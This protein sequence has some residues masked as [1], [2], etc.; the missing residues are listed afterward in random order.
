MRHKSITLLLVLVMMLAGFVS[1]IYIPK[2]EFPQ[3]DL[4][5]GLVVGVYPGASELEVE[6]Q[7]T[8][9]LEDF[10]WTFKEIDRGKTLTMSM[11]DGCAA[12]VWLNGTE[13]SKTEFWNKLK[14][15]LTL[16][17]MTLPAG[18]L[19]VVANDDFGDSSALLVTMESDDKT[20]RQLSDYMDQLKDRL[21]RVESVGRMTVTGMQKDQVSIILDNDRLARY[22]LSDR[23]LAM[24]LFSKGITTTAGRI[25]DE[26]SEQPI[27]VDRSEASVRDIEEMIVLSTPAGNVVRLK[28]VAEVRREYPSPDSYITNNG[29]KCLLLSVEMKK[30]KDI[31]AMGEAVKEQIAEFQEKQATSC[32]ALKTGA[33]IRINGGDGISY[34]QRD[35]YK[36]S[37]ISD[38]HIYFDQVTVVRGDYGNEIKV[39]QGDKE[40]KEDWIKR[41]NRN[42]H[43]DDITLEEWDELLGYAE[44]IPWSKEE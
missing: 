33:I 17:R 19:G 38:T 25:R 13:S 40:R 8:K 18:V 22:G 36:V 37:K 10:L 14:E 39:N 1:L 43:K 42:Y 32:P 16:F 34:S 21:R 11:N 9:P 35:Y 5:V 7:L 15:R 30:G 28:D 26:V 12:I 44:K 41:Y 23:T 3:V 24:T 31:V 27:Y 4:P 29:Y 2:D 20:Y 6:Q